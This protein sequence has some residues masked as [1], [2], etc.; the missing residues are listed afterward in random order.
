VCAKFDDDRL[1]NEKALVL[2]TTPTTR[3]TTFV[4]LGNPFPGLKRKPM[5][6][7][8][9]SAVLRPLRQS[10]E[11]AEPVCWSVWRIFSR[12]LSIIERHIQSSIFHEDD[13]VLAMRG[14]QVGMQQ[15]VIEGKHLAG[16]HVLWTCTVE[17]ADKCSLN[18]H[19]SSYSAQVIHVYSWCFRLYRVGQ[20]K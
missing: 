11:T 7:P 6:S 12:T 5:D 15:Q 8:I 20:K 17:I 3:R 1:W 18:Q 2:T 13:W 14:H 19:A 10:W 9:N 16:V 4:A